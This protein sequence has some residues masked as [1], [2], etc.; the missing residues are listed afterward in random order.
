MLELLIYEKCEDQVAAIMAVQGYKRLE[1][2]S[3]M[4]DMLRR[5]NTGTVWSRRAKNADM[6]RKA[7]NRIAMRHKN[8]FIQEFYSDIATKAK[9]VKEK[10]EDEM[11]KEGNQTTPVTR[12]TAPTDVAPQESNEAEIQ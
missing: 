6:C 10:A 7:A 9:K 11:R 12:P 2:T 1:M 5:G 4:D 8:L 3:P